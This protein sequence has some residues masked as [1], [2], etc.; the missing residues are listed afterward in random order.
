MATAEE[1]TQTIRPYFLPEGVDFDSLPRSVQAAFT[2]IVD[3]AYSE[4]VLAAPNALE[5]SMG[6]TFVFLLAEE[7]L[8]HFEIGRQMDL[9]QAQSPADREERGQ[10][11]NRYLKLLGAKNVAL[12]ALLRLR[13]LPSF[14]RFAPQFPPMA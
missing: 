10:A 3:P 1:Q 6:A 5:R 8:N 2:T 7:V 4:L 14:P 13:K 9:A 12:N 11:L